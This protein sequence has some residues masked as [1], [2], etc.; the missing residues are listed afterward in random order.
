MN[1]GQQLQVL[2]QEVLKRLGIADYHQRVTAVGQKEWESED[3]ST[4]SIIHIH[5]GQ[6]DIEM[7]EDTIV[8]DLNYGVQLRAVTPD[9][10]DMMET[11]MR[12]LFRAHS[13]NIEVVSSTAG[14]S[15]L[16]FYWREFTVRIANRFSREIDLRDVEVVWGSERRVQWGG[17]SVVG[18]GGG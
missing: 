11:A 2:L 16:D 8:T 7:L 12:R 5:I 1:P 3:V 4:P 13:V 14:E 10:V 17:N 15:R 6:E 9:E 18:F